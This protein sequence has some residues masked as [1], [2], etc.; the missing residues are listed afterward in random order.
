MKKKYTVFTLAYDHKHRN[1]S[2]LQY[3]NALATYFVLENTNTAGISAVQTLLGKL[4]NVKTTL[5]RDGDT[6]IIG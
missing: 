5:A 3:D 2:W 4:T 6:G 1:G